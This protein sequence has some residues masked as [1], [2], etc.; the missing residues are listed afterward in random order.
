[1]KGK[2]VRILFVVLVLAALAAG[3]VVA[4]EIDG[5]MSIGHP[6]WVMKC[7]VEMSVIVEEQPDGTNIVTCFLYW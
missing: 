6:V 1:M 2:L 4:Q 3:T 5:G 7:P